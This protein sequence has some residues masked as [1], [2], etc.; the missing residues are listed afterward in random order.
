MRV[1]TYATF[2]G[3]RYQYVG[4]R[5]TQTAANVLVRQLTAYGWTVKVEVTKFPGIGT[6]LYEIYKTKGERPPKIYV[7]SHSGGHKR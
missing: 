1:K 5:H 4:E 7:G 3:V 2:G 6:S